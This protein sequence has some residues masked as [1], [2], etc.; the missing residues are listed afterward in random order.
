MCKIIRYRFTQ[1]HTVPEGCIGC[2]KGDGLTDPIV[3]E[4]CDIAKGNIQ[5]DLPHLPGYPPRHDKYDNFKIH[6]CDQVCDDWREVRQMCAHCQRNLF[7]GGNK[8]PRPDPWGEAYN[9]FSPDKP[10]NDFTWHV[11]HCP[12]QNP[13]FRE[14]NWN[15]D[16]RPVPLDEPPFSPTDTA[17]LMYHHPLVGIVNSYENPTSWESA[18][19]R[20]V[21]LLDT[22]HDREFKTALWPT[23]LGGK[24]R[25]LRELEREQRKQ[26]MKELEQTQQIELQQQQQQQPPVATQ[27]H[28]HNVVDSHINDHS[29]QTRPGGLQWRGRDK[30]LPGA[31]GI[32]SESSHPTDSSSSPSS[33]SLPSLPSI[34]T[35]TAGQ[36]RDQAQTLAQPTLFSA[37]IAGQQAQAH[38]HPQ[39]QLD[40]FLD[41]L[42][43]LLTG[44]A[45]AATAQEQ[46]Q[47]AAGTFAD[48]PRS[49]SW[50]P[51]TPTR[52][53]LPTVPGWQPG[54]PTKRQRETGSEIDVERSPKRRGL[55]GERTRS[56]GDADST[57]TSSPERRI[58]SLPNRPF[59]AVAA[60]PRII[61][62]LPN[63]K[64][65]ASTARPG[66]PRLIL[67]IPSGPCP[68]IQ[69]VTQGRSLG[70][71]PIDVNTKRGPASTTQNSTSS[72]TSTS[73]NLHSTPSETNDTQHSKKNAGSGSGSDNGRSAPIRNS[74]PRSG[75][76]G[77]DESTLNPASTPSRTS[78]SSVSDPSSIDTPC[79][80]PKPR[81]GANLKG[82]GKI[83]TRITLKLT[84]K[85]TGV[86][87]PTT[88]NRPCTRTRAQNG[89][90]RRAPAP[91]SH[92]YTGPTT[93]ARARAQES[94]RG[95][96]TRARVRALRQEMVN[97]RV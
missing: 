63:P 87:K 91:A 95:P 55:D 50:A 66:R 77:D 90:R 16:P 49:P 88:G 8:A 48:R 86:T 74:S 83:K 52:P 14:V 54:S 76:L 69:E 59:A 82:A 38:T 65:L 58:H 15:P 37:E 30:S 4:L 80:S 62:R 97:Y 85:P 18:D 5:S 44:P 27:Q 79:P 41:Q 92:A 39:A 36:Q 25:L 43:E 46:V 2:I 22:T 17:G 45:G 20:I 6:R 23:L 13:F 12:W 33:G 61:L 1:C 10:Q 72:N 78:T 73:T 31:T 47:P 75:S 7:L 56:A 67:R 29:K 96:M 28:P 84:L 35:Q 40:P 32:H 70:R 11:E 34:P 68:T 26:K 42:C 94:E 9:V 93:R 19:G 21:D 57:R 64:T 71:R 81:S 51:S 24:S 53:R 89:P 3:Y 60:R